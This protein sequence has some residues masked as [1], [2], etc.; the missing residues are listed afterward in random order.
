[1]VGCG[2]ESEEAP[3]PAA[4]RGSG[5]PVRVGVLVPT[6]GVYAALGRDLLNGYN[7]YFEKAGFVA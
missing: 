3:T 6:S 7:L 4:R 2:Q 5:P 1:M